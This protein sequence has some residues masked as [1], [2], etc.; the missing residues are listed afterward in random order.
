VVVGLVVPVLGTGL[1]G[2]LVGEVVGVGVGLTVGDG[3]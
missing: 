3:L 2:E 1:L